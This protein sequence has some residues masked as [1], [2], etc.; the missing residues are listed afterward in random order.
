ML[1]SVKV[2][3]Y[4]C[5]RDVNVPLRPLTVL[6]GPNDSGKTTLLHAVDS[7][8]R[9]ADPNEITDHWECKTQNV[10][11][12]QA[13]TN[14]GQLEI[15]QASPIREG[16]G[17]S[18]LFRLPSEGITT[19]CHGYSASEEA[20]L[21]IGSAGE[22]IAALLDYLLRRDRRR[23]TLVENQLRE[24][25]PGL[26]SIDIGTPSPQLRDIELVI[27]NGIR[28]RAGLTSVGLRIM[29][30]FVVLAYHPHPP[31]TILLEEPENGVHPKRL[32]DVIRLLRDLTK[33]KYGGH[34]AQV[35][36]TTHSPYLLDSVR[37]EEDQVL[38]FHRNDDGSRDAKP[39]DA[40]RLKDFLGEFMLG[41]IWYNE[42]EAGLVA[43]QPT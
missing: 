5:L 24:L 34:A 3:N 30:F 17:L 33:G 6:V 19:L 42:S 43:A 41:E 11:R 27:E 15:R 20:I 2:I 12:I 16:L 25:I 13:E 8:I 14:Q 40:E 1:K 9:N 35:I 37:I 32:A 38:V 28:I 21:P 7:I 26:V 36:L 18:H 39:V 10:I 31:H 22:R 4:R 23:F 29:L